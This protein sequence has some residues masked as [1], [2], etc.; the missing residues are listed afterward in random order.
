MVHRSGDVFSSFPIDW[1]SAARRDGNVALSRMRGH[2]LEMEN[3]AVKRGLGRW[4]SAPVQAWFIEAGA[5]APY[6]ALQ[7]QGAGTQGKGSA[8]SDISGSTVLLAAGVASPPAGKVPRP[9]TVG[10]NRATVRHPAAARM[11][12]RCVWSDID[13]RSRQQ[14]ILS[15]QLMNYSAA[16]NFLEIAPFSFARARLR[17]R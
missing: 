10:P 14:I 3:D 6:I 16:P 7:P 4:P 12:H 13:T 17:P 8:R 2:E 1:Q 9:W 15:H 11:R 5:S